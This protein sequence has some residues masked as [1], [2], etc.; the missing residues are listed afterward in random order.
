[1]N[2]DE[3][4]P[5]LELSACVAPVHL[6]QSRGRRIAAEG[7]EHDRAEPDQEAV[8]AIGNVAA[9]HAFHEFRHHGETERIGAPPRSFY[10]LAERRLREQDLRVVTRPGARVFVNALLH[11]EGC[12][13]VDEI[14]KRRQVAD[15]RAGTER[16]EQTHDWS[17][18]LPAADQDH[19]GT[20]ITQI[21]PR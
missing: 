18:P 20:E 21:A 17:S 9:Q 6:A 11:H 14:G 1:M 15:R 7:R 5:A 2:A 10:R 8:P 13:L 16:V 19:Q 12:V 3:A 4:E